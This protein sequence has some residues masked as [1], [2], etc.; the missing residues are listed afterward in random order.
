MPNNWEAGMRSWV[1]GRDLHGNE[2]ILGQTLHGNEIAHLVD[3]SSHNQSP[4]S[5]TAFFLFGS[6]PAYNAGEPRNFGPG[7]FNHHGPGVSP[8]PPLTGP[9]PVSTSPPLTSQE[10][11]DSSASVPDGGTTAMMMAG[12]FGGLALL[13]KTLKV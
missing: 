5:P 11:N 9:D 10:A 6:V 1:L 2:W 4:A 3:Q 12:A 13:R 8:P 7:N